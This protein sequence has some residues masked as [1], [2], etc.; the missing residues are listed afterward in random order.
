MH[1]IIQVIIK[2]QTY[3]FFFLKIDYKYTALLKNLMINIYFIHKCYQMLS[4][5]TKLPSHKMKYCLYMLMSKINMH[6][7]QHFYVLHLPNGN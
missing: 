7:E 6:I 4:D 5:V 3:E 1:T 2:N